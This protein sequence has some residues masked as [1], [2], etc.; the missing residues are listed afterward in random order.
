M[1]DCV[2]NDNISLFVVILL[3]VRTSDMHYILPSV[4]FFTVNV[5]HMP[6]YGISYSLNQLFIH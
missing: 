2:I 4:L 6:A 1:L 3:A 5:L